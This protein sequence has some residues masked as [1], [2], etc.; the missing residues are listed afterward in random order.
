[1]TARQLLKIEKLIALGLV[2]INLVL[3]VLGIVTGV[4]IIGPAIGLVVMAVLYVIL[5]IQEKKLNGK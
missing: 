1:M 3:L 2:L 5:V 4:S